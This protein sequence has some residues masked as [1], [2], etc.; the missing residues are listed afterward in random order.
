[1]SEEKKGFLQ[2]IKTQITAGVGIFLAAMGTAFVDEVKTFIGIEDEEESA[3]EAPAQ[4][5][6]VNVEGPT[7]NITLPQQ[8]PVK[9]TTIIKEVPAKPET[10]KV[11]EPK[12]TDRLLRYKKK[13]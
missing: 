2:D 1:M 11:E 3:I 10:V 5:Q 4:S 7:I 9:Q 8:Q 6:E 13:N 12:A